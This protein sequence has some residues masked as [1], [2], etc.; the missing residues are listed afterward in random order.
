VRNRP[1]SSGHLG[2]QIIL[3]AT[4]LATCGAVYPR[5]T[6]VSNATFSQSL[7]TTD[8]RGA[9]ERVSS[10]YSLPGRG[11]QAGLMRL[12][13][14]VIPII[15]REI[16]QLLMQDGDVEVEPMRIG[17]AEMDF[18]AIMREYLTNEDRVNR[19]TRETL[20]RRG[21]DYSKFNHV[22]RE[23]ADVR[24]F[25]MGDEGV[26]YIIGQMIE[27][28]LVSRNVEEVFAPDQALRSKIFSVIKR[29]LDGNKELAREDAPSSGQG[30][31]PPASPA[32]GTPPT[33]APALLHAP[34]EQ[35]P[36]ESGDGEPDYKVDKHVS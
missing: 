15:S 28:L 32:S 10:L 30:G 33:G 29:H 13:P 25:T 35:T 26:Q 6:L 4:A 27:F 17:D 23:M 36:D 11:D 14:K 24:G 16:V 9:A 8:R 3:A 1:E 19:A 22:K 18:T 5:P 34:E 20:E 21:L 2:T 7:A 31:V 12:Y